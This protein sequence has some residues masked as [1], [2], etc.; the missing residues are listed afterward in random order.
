[1]TKSIDLFAGQSISK[2]KHRSVCKDCYNRAA[3]EYNILHKDKKNERDR[4]YRLKNRETINAKITAYKK[5]IQYEKSPQRRIWR[6]KY[7]KTPQRQN[8]RRNYMREYEKCPKRKAYNKALYRKRWDTD[9]N[10]KIARLLRGRLKYALKNNNIIKYSHA[11]DLLGCA[12]GFFKKHLESQFMEG[13]TW[14]NNTKYGWHIDHIIPV[15]HFDLRDIEQQKKCFHW[16]N[17]QPLWADDNWRKGAKLI[18]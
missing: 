14:Q 6:N 12:L 18:A 15:C 1:M 5:E 10:F 3:R 4:I 13:M 7:T 2:D 17:L 16:T 9:K 11:L 8:Y